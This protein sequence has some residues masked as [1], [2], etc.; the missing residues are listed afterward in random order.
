MCPE[1]LAREILLQPGD[2]AF[3]G[4]RDTIRTLLGSCVAVTFWHPGRRLGAMC[5]YLLARRFTPKAT[6]LDPK[7]A[8]D[9][10]PAIRSRF[11]Q[12]GLDPT[13]FEVRMF[14]GSNM[15]PDL[16]LDECLNVGARNAHE[17]KQILEACDFR[18]LSRDLSG[19]LQRM[20]VF[21]VGTG[22]VFVRQGGHSLEPAAD[23][24]TMRREVP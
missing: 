6:L 12:R 11:R 18:I 21:K 7:Y 3:A 14:G 13:E 20:V 1:A 24:S 15:F 4:E 2:Y 8:E 17:G 23:S 16:C 9:V 5:H 19:T 22:R 10:I